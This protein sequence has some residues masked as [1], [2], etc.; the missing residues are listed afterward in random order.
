MFAVARHLVSPVMRAFFIGCVHHLILTLAI[1]QRADIR[2]D[3]VDYSPASYCKA[4]YRQYI[5]MTHGYLGQGIRRVVPSCV[6]LAI[7][8]WYPSPSGT[9]MGCR[10]Y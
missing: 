5:L 1:L 10:E 3:P 8:R 7:R 2:A 6:V 4:A 9:Y